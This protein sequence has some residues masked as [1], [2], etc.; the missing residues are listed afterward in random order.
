MFPPEGYIRGLP[1]KKKKKD[2]HTVVCLENIQLDAAEAHRI[3]Y[4]G[5]AQPSLILHNKKQLI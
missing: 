5:R 3:V 1:T 2:L 4:Q